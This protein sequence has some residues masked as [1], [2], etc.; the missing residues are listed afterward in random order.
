MAKRNNKMS[1]LMMIIN[2]IAE[3]YV[4]TRESNKRMTIECCSKHLQLISR[5]VRLQL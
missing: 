3:F 4:D 1:M 5:G 2:L